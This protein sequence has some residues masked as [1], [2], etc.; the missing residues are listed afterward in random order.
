MPFDG[1]PLEWAD[2]EEDGLSMGEEAFHVKMNVALQIDH[3]VRVLCW[4]CAQLI[5][6]VNY[7]YTHWGNRD[8]DGDVTEVRQWFLCLRTTN[9]AK[10]DTPTD[11]HHTDPYSSITRKHDPTYVLDDLHCIDCGERQQPMKLLGYYRQAWTAILEHN[12]TNGKFKKGPYVWT[13]AGRRVVDH[14]WP[15]YYGFGPQ[16]RPSFRLSRP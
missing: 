6:V 4:N 9:A 13:P 16:D 10:V 11:P 14:T 8:R 15:D 1:A 3:G 12:E 5:G 2:P 7:G